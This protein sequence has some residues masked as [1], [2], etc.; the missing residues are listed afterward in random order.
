MIISN[1]ESDEYYFEEGNETEDT[2][3]SEF[4]IFYK[5]RANMS[6][7]LAYSYQELDSQVQNNNFERN[8]VNLGFSFVI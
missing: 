6:V 1:Q 7:S 5:F 3:A 8:T 4:T 2:I